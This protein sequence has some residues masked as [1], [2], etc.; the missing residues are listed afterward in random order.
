MS[1]LRVIAVL[2]VLGLFVSA[3][4][5]A[6]R[7]RNELIALDVAVETQWKQVENQLARQHEL[8]P[9]LAA[10]ARTYA[11]HEKQVFENLAASR[12]RYAGADPASKPRV[13]SALDGAVVNVLALA[14]RYP[15]LRADQHYR[16]LAYE[17]AGTK[18]RIAVERHRYNELVGLLNARLRQLPWS[19]VAQGFEAREFYEPPSDQLTEPDLAL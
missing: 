16:D 4:L 9:K 7:L 6:V 5:G 13:A 1:P 18:N 17:I 11:G 10:V 19:L 12:A 3:G 8:L 15:E 14:E 2:L